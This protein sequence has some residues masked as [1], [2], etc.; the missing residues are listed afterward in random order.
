VAAESVVPAVERSVAVVESAPDL[1]AQER[2]AT[3]D[4][5]HAEVT[6]TLKFLDQERLTVLESLSRERGALVTDLQQTMADERTIL[7]V[8]ADRM[9]LRL[10]DHAFYRAAQLAAAVMVA[11]LIALLFTLFFVKRMV[12]PTTNRS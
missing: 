9:S 4:A 8:E 6:E 7:L 1:I 3:L 11:L 2:K 5:I 10:V 12:R